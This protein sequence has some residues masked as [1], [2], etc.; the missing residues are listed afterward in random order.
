V[1]IAVLKICPDGRS[2]SFVTRLN[3]QI[4][5]PAAATKVHGIRDEDVRHEPTFRQIASKLAGFLDACDLAG[6]NILGYDARLLSCEFVRAGVHFSLQGRAIVDAK[7]I[8]HAREPRDLE[9]ACRFYLNRD[10]AEAHAALGDVQ[11]TWQVLN[12]QLKAY[13]DLPR[14]PEGLDACFNRCVDSE[15]KF[16]LRDG[17][18]VFRFGKYRGQP[19]RQVAQE[20]PDYL[21]WIA[22]GEFS[23][24]I[25]QIAAE[26]LKGTFPAKAK[27]KTGDR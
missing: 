14:D 22:K 10:H 18:A 4:P 27:A 7:Q 17:Q 11:A 13:P 6:F 2:Y 12:A 26:A 1:E 24:E 23:T 21:E 19:L 15:G 5:I 9:A 20:H 16:E 25:R 8:Y 3:P